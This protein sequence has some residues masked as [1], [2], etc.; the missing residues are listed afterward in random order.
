M[1]HLYCIYILYNTCRYM[2]IY[3]FCLLVFVHFCMCFIYPSPQVPISPY[4]SFS[5]PA[6]N[7]F[8]VTWSYNPSGFLWVSWSYVHHIYISSIISLYIWK[9]C[10]YSRNKIDWLIDVPDNRVIWVKLLQTNGW[11]AVSNVRLFIPVTESVREFPDFTMWSIGPIC[12][13]T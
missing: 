7:L 12:C 9:Q 3:L 1:I 2:Y 6:F 5:I 4:L 8:W 13:V 11:K 10:T